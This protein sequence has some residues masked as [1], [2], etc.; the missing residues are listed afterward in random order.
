MPLR[1]GWIVFDPAR[2][3]VIRECQVQLQLLPKSDKSPVSME[4]KFTYKEGKQEF[5]IM[6]RIVRKWEGTLQ[7]KRIQSETTEEYDLVVRAEVPEREFTFSAFGLSEP[8]G[9]EWT[10]PTPWYIWA[11]AAGV[12]C[13]VLGAGFAWLR[14]RAG[15]RASP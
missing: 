4:G 15:Q 6:T 12:L 8:P 14:R 1:G 5:P 13:L 7:G 11:A 10:K 2:Y 3:W 9:V